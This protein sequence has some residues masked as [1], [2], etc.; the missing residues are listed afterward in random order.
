MFIVECCP[1]KRLNAKEKHLELNSE[2]DHTALRAV[3]ESPSRDRGAPFLLNTPL[4]PEP[5]R[6]PLCSELARDLCAAAHREPEGCAPLL[7]DR[8]VLLEDL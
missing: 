2:L 3:S 6:R 8:K 1:R 7:G 5:V 4:F